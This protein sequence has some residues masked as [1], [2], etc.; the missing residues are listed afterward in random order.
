MKSFIINEQQLQVLGNCLLEFPAKNVL[1]SLDIIRNLPV[2]M[3]EPDSP[4]T[5]CEEEKSKDENVKENN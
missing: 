3:Q 4:T 1:N 2:F 5:I